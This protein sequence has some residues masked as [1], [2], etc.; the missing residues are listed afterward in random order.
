M[1]DLV[2]ILGGLFLLWKSVSEIHESMEGAE[3]QVSSAVKATP[4]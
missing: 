1:R 3:G 4:P 2:L